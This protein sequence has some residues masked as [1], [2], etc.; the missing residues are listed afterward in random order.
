MVKWDRHGKDGSTK[1]R[2]YEWKRIT[3]IFENPKIIGHDVE[4]TDVKQGQLNNCY[5]L[6]VLSAMAEFPE[7]I[8]ALIET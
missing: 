5:F 4:P 8:R 6:S 7:K 2:D 3:E 1:F